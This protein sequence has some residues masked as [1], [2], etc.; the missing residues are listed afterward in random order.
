MKKL[1]AL[2][3]AVFAL[4]I[5]GASAEDHPPGPHGKFGEKMFERLD[6]DKDG[7]VTK[8]EFLKAQ[9]EHFAKMDA[10]GDGA[11]TQEEA[12][13]MKEKFREMRKEKEGE[14]AGDV[15]PP[16]PEAPPAE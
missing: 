14:K 6:V 3:A 4:G 9:E 7:K 15:P 11:F 1:L 12:K 10:N 8:E 2:T 5:T 13:A 16:P